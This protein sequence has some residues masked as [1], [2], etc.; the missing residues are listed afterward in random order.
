M[1]TALPDWTTE[2]PEVPG[3]YWWRLTDNMLPE[4]VHLL[5]D[6]VGE[7]VWFSTGKQPPDRASNPPPRCL[8]WPVRLEHPPVG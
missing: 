1:P 5:R 7:W 8:W 2:R 4:V 3:F 6:S